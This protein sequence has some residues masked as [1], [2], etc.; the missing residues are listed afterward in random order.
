ML[1]AHNTRKFSCGCFTVLERLTYTSSAIHTLGSLHLFNLLV[2]AR[3]KNK[4]LGITGHLLYL[5]GRFT[6]CLEGP[7]SAVESVWNSILNDD[8]HGNILL[9][10]RHPVSERRF[11][12]WSMAFSSYKTFERYNMPG[13]FPV[14]EREITAHPQACTR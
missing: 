13:F 4:R 12:E 2:E 7:P 14:N 10:S 11:A 9:A 3:S 1:K 6:Q 8:R 5:D